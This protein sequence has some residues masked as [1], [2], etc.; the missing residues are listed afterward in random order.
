MSEIDEQYEMGGSLKGRIEAVLYVAGDAV[1]VD[2]LARALAVSLDELED[3]L[4]ALRDE[5][6]LDQRGFKLRR[7]GQ[8]VQLTTR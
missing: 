8:Q 3:A 7:F 5:Y 4:R 2:D 1:R 6:D